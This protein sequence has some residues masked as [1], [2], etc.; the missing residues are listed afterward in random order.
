MFDVEIKD[1]FYFPNPGSQYKEVKPLGAEF[2]KYCKTW[3]WNGLMIMASVGNYDGLQWL[4]VSFSRKSRMPTYAEMQMVKR[5]FIGD[6]KKALFILPKLKNYVNINPTCLHLWVSE[7][8]I[9]PDF[10]L[11]LGTI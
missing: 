6:D 8:D 9:V 11:G 4:H 1:T 5:D 2:A 7:K 3:E 10:D